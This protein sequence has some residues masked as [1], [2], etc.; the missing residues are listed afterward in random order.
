MGG[1]QRAFSITARR[2]LI[3]RFDNASSSREQ[4]RMTSEVFV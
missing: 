2:A 1:E 3:G 4:V